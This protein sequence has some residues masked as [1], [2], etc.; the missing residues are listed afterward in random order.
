LQKA[1]SFASKQ[2]C[3]LA[4]GWQGWKSGLKREEG[5]CDGERATGRRVELSAQGGGGWEENFL[6]KTRKKSFNKFRRVRQWHRRRRS[7]PDRASTTGAPAQATS[8][9]PR[10]LHIIY[11][12]LFM[13][14]RCGGAGVCCGASLLASCLFSRRA[15]PPPSCRPRARPN[16]LAN[17]LLL[18]LFFAFL[19]RKRAQNG[20][21]FD[22]GSLISRRGLSFPPFPLLAD[23]D[24][25]L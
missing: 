12:F 17:V 24:R 13:C 22:F 18:C 1:R 23:I 11:L 25:S 2:G 8:P 15:P 6:I 20:G 5:S 4:V 9:G 16:L 21:Q 19:A 3:L 14:R 10:S 7:P